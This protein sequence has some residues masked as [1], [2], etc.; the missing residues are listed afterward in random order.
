LRAEALHAAWYG[1]KAG[2][3]DE[4]RQQARLYLVAV[5]ALLRA[6]RERAASHLVAWPPK[7]TL[8][9]GAG[10][11]DR[12]L[13]RLAFFARYESLLNCLAVRE[14]RADARATQVLLGR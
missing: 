13:S 3:L 7:F 9:G 14:A 2:N 5:Q 4:I 12:I 10:I 11:R 6:V 8:P 1:G